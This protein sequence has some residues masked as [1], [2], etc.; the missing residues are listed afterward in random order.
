METLKKFKQF[1][2][3]ITAEKG[4]NYKISV[5]EKYKNDL[6][7]EWYLFYLLNPYITTGISDKKIQKAVFNTAYNLNDFTTFKSLLTFVS[8]HN[9]GTDD[10]IGLIHLFQD[11]YIRRL[12]ETTGLDYGLFSQ[13]ILTKNL[14]LGIDAKTVNK[15]TPGLIP[16]FDVQLANKY[17]D[18]PAI[19]EGKEFTLTTK[20]DGGRIIA[21]KKNGEAK[22]YTRQGQEYDGLVDLKAEM[23]AYMPDNVCLD[24]EITLLEPGKLTSKDQYKQTMKITRADG[25]K[26]GV[27]MIVFD[28]MTAQEFEVQRCDIPYEGRKAKLISMFKSLGHH[29]YRYF[30]KIT[31]WYT[32]N[33]TSV[34]P[35]MLAKAINNGE[36]GLMININNAPYDFKRTNN[37]LKVKKMQDIDLE[38]IGF[39]E[40]DNRHKGRLGAVLCEYKGNILKVG[41]GFSDELRNEIW[42]HQDD[43]LGRMIIVQYFEETTN[44]EGGSSLRFPVY[45][46]YR[47][48]K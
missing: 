43:W 40:G 39:E 42:E 20:I 13:R 5:L 11:K 30:T 33:D 25:E 48:D 21:I 45:L 12:T 9:T 32:G 24:G 7:I 18:N 38:I 4:R 47:T 19:V 3:E 15:V 31:E 46:D 34:I 22:F 16:T 41:S 6:D 14:P 1:V 8:E 26:H 28:I 35:V 36:E 44:A 23:E 29:A 10:V 2:E 37:L 17:F 27:K